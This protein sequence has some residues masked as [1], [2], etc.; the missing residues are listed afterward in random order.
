MN[1]FDERKKW[2]E[3]EMVESGCLWHIDLFNE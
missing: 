3:F 2:D 1:D